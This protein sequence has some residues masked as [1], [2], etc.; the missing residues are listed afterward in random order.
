MTARF[1]LGPKKSTLAKALVA[2]E[3][4]TIGRDV[5]SFQVLTNT[6]VVPDSGLTPMPQSWRTS[7]QIV[8]MYEAEY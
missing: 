4:L 6:E 3:K 2:A 5:R 7:Y 8:M 1:I